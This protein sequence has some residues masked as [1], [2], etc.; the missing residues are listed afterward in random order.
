M[1]RIRMCT[2]SEVKGTV[3]HWRLETHPQT[4]YFLPLHQRDYKQFEGN[5]SAWF[6]HHIAVNR[7]P[8]KGRCWRSHEGDSL[9]SGLCKNMDFCISLPVILILDAQYDNA[10]L[11]DAGKWDF[12]RTLLP[13]RSKDA[14]E[15]SL[16]YD[17]VGRV[18]YN[19]QSQHFI[20][21]YTS[22]D[23][24]IFTYNDMK[25][26]GAVFA[27]RVPNWTL[28][29]VETVSFYH[30]ASTQTLLSIAYVAAPRHSS[31]SITINWLLQKESIS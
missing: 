23:K 15:H 24:A 3:K 16:I 30:K 11:S 7:T 26:E 2:G 29:Y 6:Q 20:T 1:V 18:L 12:P 4:Q 13:L 19:P 27:R 8:I 22:C 25:M 17:I 21:C 5:V 28:I 14:K 10:S 31:T 9:C